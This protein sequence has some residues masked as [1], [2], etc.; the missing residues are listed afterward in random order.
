MSAVGVKPRRPCC[1]HVTQSTSL[2]AS[3]ICLL[4]M[5]ARACCRLIPIL[6]VRKY[7]RMLPLIVASNLPLARTANG[8]RARWQHVA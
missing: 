2:V 7:S 8:G 5:T 4:D 6:R 1:L 3:F